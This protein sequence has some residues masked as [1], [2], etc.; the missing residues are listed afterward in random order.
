MTGASTGRNAPAPDPALDRDELIEMAPLVRRVARLEPATAV[1]L[2]RHGDRLSLLARLPSGALIGRTVATAAGQPLDRTVRCGLLLQWLDGEHA[3]APEA[4]DAAWSGACPPVHGWQRVDSVPAHVARGLV[5]KGAE[6]H[7]QA[8]DLA[9]GGRAA[10]TLLQTPVLTVAG[11]G[12]SAPLSNRELS[13][14]I[15]MGF[16]PVDGEIVVA[17]SGRWTRAAAR[18]GSAFSEDVRGGLN[19]L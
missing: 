16:L 11:A 13:A 17:R 15:S 2:R 1:R 18:F 19:L 8:A 9:L 3:P 4:M 12:L 7:Q 5:R 6:V 14:I 10:Q